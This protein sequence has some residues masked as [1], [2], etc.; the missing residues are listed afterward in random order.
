METWL[1][2]EGDSPQAPVIAINNPIHIQFSQSIKWVDIL[3]GYFGIGPIVMR[4]RFIKRFSTI[5][6]KILVGQFLH[7]T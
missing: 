4:R 7:R 2:M 3:H 6:I 5:N 1:R